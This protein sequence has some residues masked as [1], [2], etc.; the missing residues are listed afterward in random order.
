MMKTDF[1]RLVEKFFRNYLSNDLGAS[2]QT[3]STYR[4]AFIQFLLYMKTQRHFEPEEIRLQHLTFVEL[5]SF[6]EWLET[7]RK[8]SIS[9]RNSRLAAFKS[10]AVFV[11]YESPE[12]IN[13]ADDIRRMK[14][15]KKET[16]TISFLTL[17]GIKLMINQPDRR[18]RIGIRDYAI[19]MTFFLTGI[20]VS[21][22]IEIRGRDVTMKSPRSIVIHGKGGKIRRVPIVEQLVGP[23]QELIRI[24]NADLPQNLNNYLFTN[25]SCDKLTRQGINYLIEKYGTI[26]RKKVPEL[27]PAKI[28]PH[29]LRHSC[30][31]ALIDKGT[32]LIVIRDLLGHSSVTTTE[33]YARL[34]N[35]RKR[36][37]IEAASQQLIEREDAK[38]DNDVKL[39]EWLKSLGKHTDM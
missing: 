29:K 10:F 16:S 23:L 14:A 20:R 9:T 28:S 26:A 4:Y 38:W 27:I 13:T 33:I 30:A 6:L 37:A 2:P 25:H 1:G 15:K 11:R 21:E 39:L 19:L 3:I 36:Q 22:I 32:E 24:S 34:S 35:H 31:M 7:E 8:V 5:C 12:F 18:T 17:D